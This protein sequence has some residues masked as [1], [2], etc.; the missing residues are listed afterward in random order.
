MPFQDWTATDATGKLITADDYRDNRLMYDGKQFEAGRFWMGPMLAKNESGS[1]VMLREIARLFVSANMISEFVKRHVGAVLGREPLWKMTTIRQVSEDA[2]LSDDER[3]RIAE[4]EALLTTWWDT[5]QIHRMFQAAATTLLLAG[6]A[7]LRIFVPPGLRDANGMLNAATLAD[8][9]PFFF[10]FPVPAVE[11]ATVALDTNTM[12]PC[13]VFRS[14]VDNKEVIEL[15]Y[16]DPESGATVW[17]QLGSEDDDTEY[18]MSMNGA[19]PMFQME[20]PQLIT[21]PVRQLQMLRNLALSMLA[22]NLNAAGSPERYFFN[23]QLPG[24]FVKDADGQERFVANEMYVGATTTNVL[25]GTPI[26]R[27]N[28]ET[29]EEE[30]TG[31]ATPNIVVRDPVNITTYDQAEQVAYRAGLREVHQLHAALGDAA[32][33]GVSRLNARTDFVT[34]LS[35]TVSTVNAAGRWI[36]ETILAMGGALAA[37]DAKR[38]ADLRPVFYCRID[39]GPISPEEQGQI[40]ENFIAGLIDRETAIGL[41]GMDDVDAIIERLEREAAKKAQTDTETLT[42]ALG[43]SGDILNRLEGNSGAVNNQSGT[44]A[45]G[46]GSVPA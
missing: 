11:D 18:R 19:L 43:R 33:S 31:Y 9:L 22:L 21:A 26:T 28:P 24:T 17:R 13:G 6:R 44:A 1:D 8:A 14:K 36:L 23:V 39:I 37:K 45:P 3:A 41:L 25:Q 38:F 27:T 2:P 15:V 30:V 40:R 42:T 20:A 32:A 35:P 12:R 10:A 4:A 46:T 5:R 16:V 29:L 7:P 34:S